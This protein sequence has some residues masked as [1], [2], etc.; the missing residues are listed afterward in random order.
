MT[1]VLRLPALLMLFALSVSFS[2]PL[3]GVLR[4]GVVHHESASA[5]AVHSVMDRGEHGHED[6]GSLP[7]HSHGEGH[8]HGTG[9]DHCTHQ[10]GQAAPATVAFDVPSVK[11]DS[12]P[13]TSSAHSGQIL[14][15][16][17]HPPRA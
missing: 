14:R 16:Q 1:T 10:H 4:D 2:E 12:P 7:G 13:G 6:D 15:A 5:A 9:A 17:F 8:Q 3:L 11:S